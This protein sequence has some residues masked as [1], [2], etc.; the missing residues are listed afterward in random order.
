MFA[1][2]S[3]NVAKVVYRELIGRMRAHVQLADAEIN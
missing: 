3:S 1:T 2:S